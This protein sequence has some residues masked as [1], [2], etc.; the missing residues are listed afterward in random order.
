M[1]KKLRVADFMRIFTHAQIPVLSTALCFGQ[2][3]N[4]LFTVTF[5]GIQKTK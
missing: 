4:F 3:Q 5:T 1:K 2:K